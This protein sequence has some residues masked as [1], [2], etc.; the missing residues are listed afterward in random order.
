MLHLGKVGDKEGARELA[1]HALDGGEFGAQQLD[2]LDAAAGL[3]LGAAAGVGPHGSFHVVQ[4][5]LGLQSHVR[6][7]K[8]HYPVV[9]HIHTRGCCR[10]GAFLFWVHEF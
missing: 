2:L 3:A 5:A 1:L 8:L 4:R 6:H 10:Q 9:L 7:R